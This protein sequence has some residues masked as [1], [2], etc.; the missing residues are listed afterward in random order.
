M[1]MFAALAV[2]APLGTGLYAIDGFFVVALAT[3]LVP[4]ITLVFVVPLSPVEP[5]VVCVLGS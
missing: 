5:Q 2:G 1:A 3:A 4:L